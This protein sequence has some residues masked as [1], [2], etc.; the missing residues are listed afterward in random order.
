M[1]K[2]DGVLPPDATKM[3]AEEKGALLAEVLR[4]KINREIPRL[5]DELKREANPRYHSSFP[6]PIAR[7]NPAPA[8]TLCRRR[9]A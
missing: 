5:F 8:T 1:L 3:F 7:P 6:D 2:C 4:G 9:T